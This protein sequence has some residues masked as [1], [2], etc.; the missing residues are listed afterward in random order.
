[1][2][3]WEWPVGEQL[4]PTSRFQIASNL[5]RCLSSLIE[6]WPR[7]EAKG[8]GGGGGGGG[9]G[10]GRQWL[11]EG[12]A[13]GLLETEDVCVCFVVWRQSKE[14][15]VS[16]GFVSFRCRLSLLRLHSLLE[17]REE[18][19]RKREGGQRERENVCLSG[20]GGGRVHTSVC[21][22]ANERASERER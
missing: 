12:R 20:E 16:L 5:G 9:V 15:H 10:G 18:G 21:V 13:V 14:Q 8:W 19:G 4:M 17:E 3:L 1:M 2:I 7:E 22:C 11:Q 6:H